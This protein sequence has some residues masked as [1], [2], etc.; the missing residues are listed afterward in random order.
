MPSEQSKHTRSALYNVN[1]VVCGLATIPRQVK[2]V[3]SLMSSPLLSQ[4][5]FNYILHFELQ[6]RKKGEHFVALVALLLHLRINPTRDYI[7]SFLKKK[8][9]LL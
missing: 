5:A 9:P 7:N 6:I 1:N 3:L 8:S 2:D 4:S